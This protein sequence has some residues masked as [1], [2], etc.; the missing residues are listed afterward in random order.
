MSD[1]PFTVPVFGS[2]TQAPVAASALAGATLPATPA[3]VVGVGSD[4]AAQPRA[5]LVRVDAAGNMSTLASGAGGNPGTYQS[6][7]NVTAASAVSG[8][9]AMGLYNLTPL[10]LSLDANGG[11]QTVNTPKATLRAIATGVTCATNKALLS[12]S[13]GSGA[14]LRISHLYINVPGAGASGA[15]LGQGSSTYYPLYCELWRVSGVTGGSSLPLLPSDTA[16]TAA[17]GVTAAA[18][19]TVGARQATLHRRDAI[20][21]SNTNSSWYQVLCSTEQN[22]LLRPG[23]AVAVVCVSNGTITT[24]SGST[25]TASVDVACTFTQASA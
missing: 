24:S 2:S 22:I 25:G 23:E 18:A 14:M 16:V 1:S 8:Q 6:G 15:L 21:S 3:G 12:V 7:V 5:Q 11:L 13:N 17:S 20:P 10:P 9:I 4:Y 19:P